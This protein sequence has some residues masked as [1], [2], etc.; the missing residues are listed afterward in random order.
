MEGLTDQDWRRLVETIQRGTCV[1]L[2]GPG[3]AIDEQHPQRLPL[4][5]LLGQLL[6]SQ[7]DADITVTEPSD[8]RHIAQLFLNRPTSDRVDLEIAVK[9]FHA[10][11]AK[12]TTELHKLLAKLPFNLC[13][14]TTHDRFLSNAFESV[15]K[16]PQLAHYSFRKPSAVSGLSPSSR[17]P[18][19]FNLYGE[20]ANEDSLVLTENDLLDF[21]VSV[22]KDRP[23]LP[24]T[25]TARFSAPDTS[26]LFLGFGFQRW[27]VR[28]LLHVLQAARHRYKSLAL[29]DAGFFAH[30]DQRQTAVFFEHEHLIRFKLL[31]WQDFVREL[32]C[33]VTAAMANADAASPA[34]VAA[35]HENDPLVFLCHVH[36]D[37]EVV[38][39]LA[40]RLQGMGIRVWL[41]RQNL[42][43]GDNWDRL[44]KDVIGKHVDYVAILQSQQMRM[45]VRSYVFKEIDL[46]LQTQQ[47]F[48]RNIRFILPARLAEGDSL[49]QLEH[50]HWIDLYTDKGIE[51]LAQAIR[52][53]WALR[54][55]SQVPLRHV[56]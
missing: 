26:F 36:E 22:I 19:V 8:F 45:Q 32:A 52:E 35:A 53:D 29:E 54:Q 42:R 38:A 25:V 40:D 12:R 21:L 56:S 49:E 9:D 24:S 23:P 37:R 3:V 5:T 15:G 33:Q 10:P 6:A 47:Q 44:I 2:L 51:Q 34:A 48:A 39:A 16:K 46:A 4:P 14:N 55:A 43:G 31:S 7:L 50:L 30:P 18:L 17:S 41:D 27:Y 11:Y 28:I 13:I 20:I 1:L